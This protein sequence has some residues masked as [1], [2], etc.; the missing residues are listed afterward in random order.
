[1]RH[2]IGRRRNRSGRISA[3]PFLFLSMTNVYSSGRAIADLSV[4]LRGGCGRKEDR[5]CYDVDLVVRDCE[6]LWG[7]FIPREFPKVLALRIVLL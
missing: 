1:M 7:R 4:Q 5:W 2:S 6:G 3:P